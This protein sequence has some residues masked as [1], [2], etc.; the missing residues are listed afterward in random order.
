MTALVSVVM[1]THNA[2]EFIDA[3]IRSVIKQTYI[4]W[5]LIVWDNLSVDKTISVVKSFKDQRIKLY[6]SPVFESLGQAR[7][8]ALA[9]CNGEFIAFLDSDDL[10]RPEKLELQVPV[11]DDQAVGICISNTEFFDEHSSTV[12]YRKKKPKVGYVF[13]RLLKENFL[14]LETV[15]LRKACLEKMEQPFN[16][17]FNM[18]EEYDLFLRICCEWRLAYVDK[19]LAA[20]RIHQNSVTQ[21]RPDLLTKEMRQMLENLILETPDFHEKY[22]KELLFQYNKCL[23]IDVKNNLEI[24]NRRELFGRIVNST[25]SLPLKILLTLILIYPRLLDKL[26]KLRRYMI[27]VF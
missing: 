11:F 9:L 5:E 2:E 10:W 4:N 15:I 7:N 17:K 13:S 1:N 3:A 26:V 19:V 8:R 6:V 14:S 12:L 22:E 16:I 18:I 23:I 24:E 21:Q 25:A 20:W 27:D